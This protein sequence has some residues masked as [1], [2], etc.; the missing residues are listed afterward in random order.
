MKQSILLNLEIQDKDI[1]KNNQNVKIIYEFYK[2]H[3][4]EGTFQKQIIEH[5]KIGTPYLPLT[6]QGAQTI[7]DK[8]KN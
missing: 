2:K 7:E 6:A 3:S 4:D 5:K 8:I 1:K